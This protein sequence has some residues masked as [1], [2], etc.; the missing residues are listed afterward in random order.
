M[1]GMQGAQVFDWLL[2]VFNFTILFVLF[3]LVVIIPMEQAVK[4]R[5]QRVRL[6]LEEI[7]QIAAEAKAKQEEF[8][9]KFSHV[10]EA[11][12][13]IKAASERTLAQ[14]R[15]KI[16]EKAAAEERYLLGK[17]D[18]EAASLRREVEEE[19]RARVA[20]QAV[21]KAEALLSR[22]LDAGA[23]DAVVAAGVRK[24]GEL[25]AT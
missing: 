7:E 25:S 6:R 14:S 20:S 10:E 4:L 2:S 16:E 18:A 13:E 23:Q 9:A 24:V 17:A 3:R 12:S 1:L 19:I 11:L 15:A 21:A 5:E 22:A 8:E